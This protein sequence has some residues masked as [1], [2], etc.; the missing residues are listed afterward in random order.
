MCVV[1]L[2]DGHRRAERVQAIRKKS[3]VAR[4]EGPLVLLDVVHLATHVVV[5]A[6][7]VD[8]TLKEERLVRNAQLVH[9]LQLL[10]GLGHRV[11]QVHFTVSVR[12]LSADEDDLSRADRQSRA[13]PQRVPHAHGV[14]DPIILFDFKHLNCVVDLLLSAAKEAT[15]GINELIVDRASR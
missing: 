3:V 5:A 9:R 12:V 6:N 11:E 1:S 7:H 15:K 2:L 4:D 8:F 14:H 10:P 13:R